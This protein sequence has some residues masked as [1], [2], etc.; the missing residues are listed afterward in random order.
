MLPDLKTIKIG[1]PAQRA[2]EAAGIDKA[3]LSF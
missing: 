1:E 2:L 3:L